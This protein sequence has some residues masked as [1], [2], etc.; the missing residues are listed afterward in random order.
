MGVIGAPLYPDGAIRTI[1]RYLSHLSMKN[2]R[3]VVSYCAHYGGFPYKAAPIRFFKFV[4][5]LPAGTEDP[6]IQVLS[7]VVDNLPRYGG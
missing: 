2:G 4:W 1:Y 6:Q 3:F 5:G 7:I